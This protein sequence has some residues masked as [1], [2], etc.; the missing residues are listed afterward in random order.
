MIMSQILHGFNPLRSDQALGYY[1]YDIFQHM[2]NTCT[3]NFVVE[4]IVSYKFLF[5]VSNTYPKLLRSSW[6]QKG[7]TSLVL[8]DCHFDINMYQ[9]LILDNNIGT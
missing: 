4:G 1:M 2:G 5:Q 9:I 3:C 8:Q 7:I 6:L